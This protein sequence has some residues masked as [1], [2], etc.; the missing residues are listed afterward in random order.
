MYT[1]LRVF[2]NLQW[3]G[4]LCWVPLPLPL[5]SVVWLTHTCFSFF[6]QLQPACIWLTCSLASLLFLSVLR[7]PASPVWPHLNL[8]W[9]LTWWAVSHHKFCLYHH[10][11]TYSIQP[12]ITLAHCQS[13]VPPDLKWKNTCILPTVFI[14]M[15]CMIGGIIGSYL[16]KQY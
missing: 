2:H 4:A 11:V 10:E 7:C 15:F 16:S 8:M 14:D 13:F 12:C 1:A 6:L 9:I 3:L 5:V